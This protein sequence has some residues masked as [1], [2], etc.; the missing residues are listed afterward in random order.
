MENNFLTGQIITYMG[1][2]RKL[3]P[4]IED[5]VDKLFFELIHSKTKL[6]LKKML[7]INYD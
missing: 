5:S 1:N 6:E 3:L 7:N 4:Y 2:K